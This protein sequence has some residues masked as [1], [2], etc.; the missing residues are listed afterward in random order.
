ME[1]LAISFLLIFC[2]IGIGMPVGFALGITGFLLNV[3]LAKAQLL[4]LCQNMFMGVDSYSLLAIPF[5]IYAG[6]LMNAGGISKRLIDL[7]AALVGA[8]R[9]GLAM[10]NILA[11]MFFGGMSGTAAA[12]TAAIGG[13]M[14]PAMIKRN[15]G[16]DYSVAVTSASSS[17]GIII[18][19]SVPFILYGEVSDISVAVLF[20]AGIVPG[21]LLGFGLMIVAYIIA[22]I[23]KYPPEMPAWDFRQ[24]LKAAKVAIPALSIPLVI[25]GGILGGI[26]TPTEAGAI[27]VFC[28]LIVGLFIYREL[29]FKGLH[30]VT[31]TAFKLSAS[32]MLIVAGAKVL[33]YSFTYLE[34]SQ[35]CVEAL[36]A[37]FTSPILF[38]LL[39]CIILIIAGVILDGTAIVF[40]VIPLLIP[41]VKLVGL[42]PLQFAIVVILCWAIGQQT[43]PVASGLYVSCVLGGIDMLE[44]SRVNIWF[45]GVMVFFLALAVFFPESLLWFPHLVYK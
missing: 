5:F 7:S 13:V 21:I 32:V 29:D 11:S 41:S 12:D 22:R 44:A 35:S 16:R 26:F 18:P 40:V 15:Y 33:G 45:I 20:V 17:L 25:V 39:S 2:L 8:M 14:I 30:T 4:S 36:S 27:A 19:P 28:A 3:F 9:G 10:I 1:L 42:D 24:I 43:P 38:M 6:L 37:Y 31:V 34:I 23:R